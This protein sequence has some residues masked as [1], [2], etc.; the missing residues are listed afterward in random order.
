MV[1][2]TH[3][4]RLIK[5]DTYIYYIN[6]YISLLDY[7]IISIDI[8]GSTESYHEWSVYRFD[9]LPFCNFRSLLVHSYFLVY[10][11][12]LGFGHIFHHHSYKN[13]EYLPKFKFFHSK[14]V[15]SCFHLHF[16]PSTIFKLVKR[17]LLYPSYM[18]YREQTEL[19]NNYLKNPRYAVI[20]T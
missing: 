17:T 9:V 6:T 18:I 3:Q 12:L 15:N 8:S 2:F 5:Y 11:I 7:I 10:S 13:I 4:Y 20:K 1:T 14:S 19:E 16:R